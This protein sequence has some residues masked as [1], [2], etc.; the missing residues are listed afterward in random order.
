MKLFILLLFFSSISAQVTEESLKDLTKQISEIRTAVV[1]LSKEVSELDYEVKRISTD[2]NVI[3][4]KLKK[5]E[6]IDEIALKINTLDEKII[7]LNRYIED[8]K[9]K[10]EKE[11]EKVEKSSKGKF[12]TLISSPQFNLLALTI[13]MFALL[14]AVF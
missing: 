1:G 12:E 11:K 14:L 13:S 8:L 5:L 10:L 2:N 9:S 6:K 3:S 4:Q 7:N